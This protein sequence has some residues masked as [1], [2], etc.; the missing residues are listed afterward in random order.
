MSDSDK[1]AL[2][3]GTA[4]I[5]TEI[6][7]HN[8]NLFDKNN[9]VL[10]NG[11]VNAGDNTITDAPLNRTTYIPCEPNTTYTISKRNNGDTNRFAV[12]TSVDL[13]AIGV[14]TYQGIRTDNANS[15][16]IT[17]N[18]TANYLVFFFY[19]TQ[20]TL[21][22]LEEMLDSIRIE[23]GT[24]LL[25][26][27]ENS[28]I[29]WNH[30]DFRYVKNQGWIGQFV[31]RQLTG[32]LKN[33][34]D[35]FSITDKELTLKLGIRTNDNTN[36]YSLGNFIVT[37]VTDNEVSDKTTF[38]ALD[39]TK[40]FNKKYEDTITYPCTALELAQ[41][42]CEQCGVQFGTEHFR[43][44]DYEI[45]GN[46][47]VNNESCRD[48]MKAIGQLAF[49]WVRVDWD[50]KVYIDFDMP[51][52]ASSY[53]V[54]DNSKYYTL[55]THKERFGPVNRVIVGYSQIEGERTKIENQASIEEYGVCELTIYDNPLVFT[56]EQREFI[57]HEADFLMNFIYTPVNAL[58][59]G[60]PWLKANSAV[61]VFDMENNEHHT[62]PFDRTI[63]YFGHIKTLI[64]STGTSTK[65]DTKYAYDPNI[66]SS[67]KRTEI[68]VDKQN[69]TI[70]SI[71]NEIGDRSQK[72]T[73]ITQDIDSIVSQIQDIPTITVENENIGGFYLT[74]LLATRVIELKIHPTDTD[75]IG[76]F[77]SNGLKVQNGLK[78]L[79]N[80]VTFESDHDKYYYKI[81][82]NLYYLDDVYD[83]FLYDGANQVV[84]ITHRIGIDEDDEKYVL[85]E[86]VIEYFDYYDML[87][88]N[89]DY[90]IYMQS[91][92]TAYIYMKAMIQNDYTNSFAT[93]YELNSTIEQTADAITAQ[94]NAKADENNIIAKLNLAI[95]NGKG[96]VTL[97]GNTVIIDSDHFK[98]DEEGNVF[99]NSALFGDVL[100]D[101]DEMYIPI[102]VDYNYT[103]DDVQ[104]LLDIY[105]G[106]IDP[107][108][109]DYLKYDFNGDG[110]LLL[111]D[112][113][114]LR[115]ILFFGI[116]KDTPG[117]ILFKADKLKSR[118]TIIGG[119][120]KE[121]AKISFDGIVLTDN[122]EN[123]ME[124]Y[125]S[126]LLLNDGTNSRQITATNPDVPIGGITM[127]AG[128]TAP[129]NYM[130]CDGTAISRTDYT[131]LFDVI[132][133]TYGAGDGSTTFN[134]P[135]LKGR[136]PVG[137]D[138]SQS[139]FNSIGKTGGSKTHTLTQAQMPGS[140]PSV[141]QV[142]S[143]E[144][145]CGI[146]GNH[147]TGYGINL[148]G[149]YGTSGQ[150]QPHNI[151]QPYISLNYIIRVN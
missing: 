28:V 14:S 143:N 100:V 82:K 139:E 29:N 132:G 81:P 99:A 61:T 63:Q 148:P 121:Y 72:Q 40:L 67:T 17:T 74:N 46:V 141:R 43:N 123:R 54:I 42:V 115:K 91:Y 101:D 38:E 77:V 106:R 127:Y 116:N 68:M 125:P 85:D 142:G 45:N 145:S 33:L 27:E 75:I 60:H 96:V 79:A 76:L 48:V 113:L 94:V 66:Y 4:T 31:A 36:W 53:D 131:R 126:Q 56:Q 7:V 150:G 138:S 120:G 44:D 21:I 15:I 9:A 10:I 108:P 102:T 124:L 57:I 2:I 86:P 151:M 37:K 128:A 97:K 52:E 50:N 71:V 35:D 64:D 41:N 6:V 83:E 118:I 30:E 122:N 95:E 78:V 147:G 1:Q 24:P 88:G 3:D 107:T 105:M 137:Y 20:E 16:T 34:S 84:Q 149:Q 26:T 49:S 117:K 47:F 55:K 89:G 109:E 58:T 59:I 19:R 144:W 103:E 87:I 119:N 111:N 98:L 39:Y 69:Q 8:E 65:S 73:T 129:S 12:A 133:T 134:L 130:I 13:P 70:T 92:P 22:T 5:Q 23:E 18:P 25:L 90:H 112:V 114:A 32:T 110:R 93:K 104:R 140:V 146:W 62:M 80:G 51:R 11:T 136:V 135:N